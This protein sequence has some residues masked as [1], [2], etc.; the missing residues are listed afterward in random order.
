MDTEY[1]RLIDE[2]IQLELLVSELY[3]VFHSSFPE[4]ASFWWRLVEEER[5]HAALIKSAREYFAP[6]DRF[7]AGMVHN[8]LSELTEVNAALRTLLN[9]YSEIPPSRNEAFRC[10]LDLEVTA[11][12]E[13]H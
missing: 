3:L 5:N 10:A 9:T 7:P 13:F 6:V 4:D 12:S 2:S 8:N 1:Y 11:F